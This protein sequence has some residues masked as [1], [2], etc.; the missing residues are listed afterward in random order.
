MLTRSIGAALRGKATRT[1]VFLA[2]F[3]AGLLGF[4]PGFFLP[5][6]LG[7]GFLQAPGLIALLVFLVLVLNA[8]LAVFGLC[9]LVAKLLS[10]PLMGVAFAIG[11]ALLDGPLQGLFRALINAKVTAWFGLE[12][13]A[14]TGGLVLGVLF[15]ALAGWGLMRTLTAIRTH[16]V[17]VEEHSERYQKWSK[18]R[19]VR[20][21]AWAFLGKGKGKKTWKQLVE[22]KGGMPVRIVG[23]VAVL[24]L[25]GGLWVFQSWLSTPMLTA[26]ARD[27][28][29]AVN[30]ATVDLKE[31]RLDLGGGLLR[32][33]DLA[34]ADA[35]A[36]DTDAFRAGVL[37]ARIDTGELLR[38][39]LVIDQLRSSNASSGA[40]RTVPGV[41]VVEPAE[42]PPPPP[43]PGSKTLDD[44]LKDVEKWKQRLDQ[45]RDWLE[46][47]QGDGQPQD[48]P[49]PEP[50]LEAQR[51][52]L[53]DA[54]VRA[55]HLLEDTPTVLIRSV[56]IDG[57]AV[58]WLGQG[59][60]LDLRG[61]NLSTAP[62]LV[63]EAMSL[64]LASKQQDKLLLQL[65]GPAAGNGALGL[66][67]AYRGLPVDALF[68]QLKLG[69]EAPLRGGT[70]DVGANGSFQKRPG[71]AA[72]ID[73]PLQV[74]LQ[75]TTFAFPGVQP[76][77]VDSLLLPVGVRGALVAPSIWLDDKS[78]SDALVAAGKQELANFV[79]AQAGQLLGGKLPPGLGIDP[80]KSAQEQLDAAR[81][82]A[83]AEA[84][85]RADEAAEAAKQKALEEAKKKGV[86]LERLKG[87]LPGGKKD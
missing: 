81:K 19:S 29:T 56:D 49:P 43:E 61:R 57:I 7:G 33:Q 51:Q 58:D 45:L 87:L 26:A 34:V 2:A 5:S 84:K 67:F 22:Q 13:Y 60:L 79:N 62:S 83:E 20:L 41:L 47:L 68:A 74:K 37:E 12:Y 69:G 50:E 86:D 24:L 25:A 54:K 17:N 85:K 76:T 21:L 65:S 82:A 18:K 72:T 23:V 80:T 16:M 15:G 55:V 36:L 73:L 3:L 71:T 52:A 9:L 44:Y 42:P 14:T 4:V 30:G 1:Q 77:K 38:K 32:L 53:G 59:Q 11:R 28:L 8:N 64:T 75:Q 31:A 46:V 48:E 40:R 35:A 39:R 63:A 78:L 6:D 70:I 27:G 66:V 10:L